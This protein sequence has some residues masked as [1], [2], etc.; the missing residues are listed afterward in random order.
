M[1]FNGFF[2]AIKT[3]LA[4]SVRLE[5]VE[6]QLNGITQRLDRIDERID[7][8]HERIDKIYDYLINSRRP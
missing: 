6:S 4:I 5:N 3:Y 2:R 1:K 7:Y 8:L